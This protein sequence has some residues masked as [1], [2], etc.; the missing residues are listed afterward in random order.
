ML[1]KEVINR[2]L[3]KAIDICEK[4][5][6][7]WIDTEAVAN[8]AYL[9]YKDIRSHEMIKAYVDAKVLDSIEPIFDP[10]D[11]IAGRLDLE[12]HPENDAE[13]EASKER[14]KARSAFVSGMLSSSNGHVTLDYEK[15]LEKGFGG[16]LADVKEKLA[17]ISFS[18]P[19]GIEKRKFYEACII[20]L[21]AAHRFQERY[22]A[23]ASRLA[24][25]ETDP[26]RKKNLE[27][28][29]ESLSR[30]PYEPAQTFYDAI[31]AVWLYQIMVWAVKEFTQA[32]RPDNYLYPFYKKDLA[33]GR[34]TP[35]EAMSL[36]E[37]WY[38]RINYFFSVKRT[39]ATSLMIGGR[40]RN[41]N[42]VCNEL[43]YMF[44][45]AIETTGVLHPSVG[46]AYNKEIPDDLLDLCLE[47]NAKG[48]TRPSIFN[49]DTI[50]KGLKDAGCSDED[51]NYYIHSTCVEI[52]PIATS[53]VWVASK[54]INLNKI[55]EYLLNG[56][57]QIHK[58][59]GLR[60]FAPFDSDINKLDTFEKFYS[61]IKKIV[62]NVLKGEILLQQEHLMALKRY[63]SLPLVDCFIKDCIE[64][65][66]N[67]ANGGARY[68]FIYP[69]F[70]GFSNFVDAIAAIRK[71]VYE[72][73]LVTFEELGE[74]IKNNFEGFERLHAFLL[75]KC[76]KFCNDTPE[77][78]DIAQD[79]FKYICDELSIFKGCVP[80]ATFH[81][82]CFAYLH[83][84]RLGL[85]ASASPDGR[86]DSEA[87]SECLGAVQGMDKN[88][89]LALINSLCNIPQERG[90]GGIATNF[91]FSK[92]IMRENKDEIRA[93]VKDFMRR[94][95]FEMQFNVIDQETLIDAK[96]H[97]EK[98]RTLM[99]R[100]AGYSDYFVML[101][102]EIQ[103]EVMKRLEH[104]D[105]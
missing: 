56:G 88:G 77:V 6:I 5:P 68:R 62:D 94:G 69:S 27:R 18:D 50:I 60:F 30:V 74:A 72:E 75:N 93:L 78:D 82:S 63:S 102:N 10:D 59:E 71:A 104:D 39:P 25:I 44:V 58:G 101:P 45:K 38:L 17:N 8:N 16:V 32:G 70:P 81:F 35:D 36:I 98:Y 96:A 29:A 97:P 85:E 64:K 21:E 28:M 11:L 55:F 65:G 61:E 23:E 48:F 19:E 67:S 49:D 22:C 86:K 79:M 52:T 31:Q 99:V 92:K 9:A 73:K 33:E 46:L 13:R 83:H 15:L 14:C 1:S 37:D 7:L 76:P 66:K 43:S 90:I 26:E 51:A 53:N 12:W 3:Q 95:N 54:Y 42:T 91:R 2:Q 40:D 47:M 100:V 4:R 103:N 24:S 80:N 20:S 84:G 87:L 41:G 57:E 105:L 89:P 34:I